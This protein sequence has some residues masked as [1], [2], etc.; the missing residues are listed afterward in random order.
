MHQQRTGSIPSFLFTIGFVRG[1][2]CGERS[3]PVE[4]ETKFHDM[5]NTILV[6]GG[7]GFIGSNFILQ[8]MERDSAA[9]V[10]LDKLTYAGNLR[11]LESVA[12]QRRYEF[13]HG[14]IADR[15]LVRGLLER[16]KP[17]AIVHFAA[18]SHVD[19]SIRGPDDFIRTNVDGTF[20]LLEEVR[21][22]WNGLGERGKIDFRFL[23]VSTDEVY[24]SLGPEDAAFSETTAYAPNS[25]YAA[26]KAASDH[27]VRAYHHTYGLPVLTTNCSNNYGRFQFPEKL[28][29][30]VILNAR[31]GKP[32]PVYGDGQNVRDWLYVEDH[33]AAIA[34]VL[35]RGRVGQTYNIGGWNEKRNIEI[36]E[37]ICDIV[38]EMAGSR[39]EPRRGLITFVKD[40]PGHDRRYAMDATKIERELGWSPLETF[41]SGIRKTV[42]W[43]LENSEWVRDVTSGGYRQWIETHYSS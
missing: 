28:I 37:T 21:A 1:L 10:N 14:D 15:S 26:S 20:A 36:V 39:G 2:R 18:E 43:Y 5:E 3:S 23:H 25:P 30:L 34:E 33:C 13:V 27:F 9:V 24:G 38:D 11:N 12:N 29:P 32:L 19:R 4:I 40:R 16:R 6:T 31:D 42:Q 41:E 35:D 7:A 22:Y 17:R 8:G